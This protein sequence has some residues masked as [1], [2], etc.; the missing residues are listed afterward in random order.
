MKE[1][2]TIRVDTEIINC[3]KQECIKEMKCHHHS[4][5]VPTHHCEKQDSEEHMRRESAENMKFID[6]GQIDIRGLSNIFDS[7]ATRKTYATGMFNL[8]LI[9]TNFTQMKHIIAVTPSLGQLSITNGILLIFVCV[10]LLLQ[11]LLNIILVFL[12]KHGEF[13]DEEKREQLIKS[14]NAVTLIVLAIS[15]INV[16]INVFLNV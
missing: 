6:L 4:D 16:F 3:Y 15:I 7:Y 11:L 2:P 1:H 13:Y 10:S 8:A 5:T 14:N 12:A 9:A